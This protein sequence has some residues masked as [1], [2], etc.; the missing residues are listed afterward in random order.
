MNRERMEILAHTLETNTELRG[1]AF[2]MGSLF[3]PIHLL[4]YEYDAPQLVRDIGCGTEGCIAGWACGLF[5]APN[6]IVSDI[7]AGYLLDLTLDQSNQ[8]FYP[9]PGT[10][11]FDMAGL[12]IY[13][14]TPIQAAA[15]VRKLMEEPD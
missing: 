4:D 15:A 8:L 6:D 1:M 3:E 14:A 13:E 2:Y 5:G 12:P 10:D 7:A 11:L 9:G